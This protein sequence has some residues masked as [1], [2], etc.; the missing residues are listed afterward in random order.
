MFVN[1]KTLFNFIAPDV[2]RSQL[3]KLDKLFE[4]YLL[5]LITDAG[6]AE[7]DRARTL[8]EYG[9]TGFAHTSSNSVL[10]SMN[11]PGFHY[12]YHSLEAG[13]VHSHAVPDTLG[14]L[15]HMPMGAIKHLYPIEALRAMYR[16][17]DK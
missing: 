14:R 4:D 17:A 9:Q 8:S 2:S 10:G 15:N 12:K 16:T 6:I 5:F 7:A 1:E 11:D 3:R 13:G